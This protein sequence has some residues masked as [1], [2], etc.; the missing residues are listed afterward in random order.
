MAYS[1]P[2]SVTVAAVAKSLPR[3]GFGLTRG[4]FASSDRKY[5]LIISHE[6]SNRYRHLA[7]LRLDDVVDNPLVDGQKVAASAWAHIV[8]DMPKNG[9][10]AAAVA[11]IANA[12]VA[13]ATPANI[14]KLIAGEN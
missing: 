8:V 14:T 11:D 1:D 12:L 3:T 13:W 4:E 5:Q 7:Q 10:T 6:T 9:L 2:Q